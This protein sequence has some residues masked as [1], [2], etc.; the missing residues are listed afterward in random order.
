MFA[1]DHLDPTVKL[2][3]MAKAYKVKNLTMD[4]LVAE[5]AKCELVCHNCHAFRTYIERAHDQ[6]PRTE[7]V[8]GPEPLFEL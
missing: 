3:T 8:S 1:F 4:M 2:F 6:N 5:M 7:H